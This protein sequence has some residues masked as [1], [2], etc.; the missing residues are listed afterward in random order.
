[1]RRLALIVLAITALVVAGCSSGDSVQVVPTPEGERRAAPEFTLPDLRGGPEITLAGLRGK[2]VLLNFWAT[3]CGPCIEETPAIAR[4]ATEHPDISV[5]GVA[6][7]D[8]P[9]DSLKFVTDKGA[10]YPHAVDRS[11]KL[12]GEYGSTG[13]PTTVLIDPA[14]KVITTVFGP[15]GDDELAGIAKTLRAG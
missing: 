11:G 12:L 1:M 15:V 7:M 5:L 6:S 13:L 3:W 2:P 10:A 9:D 4:F 8:R 14:G